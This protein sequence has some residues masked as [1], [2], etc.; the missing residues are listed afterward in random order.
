MVASNT[1]PT[2]FAALLFLLAAT[3]SQAKGDIIDGVTIYDFSSEFAAFGRVADNLINGSGLAGDLHEATDGVGMWHTEF[4]DLVPTENNF[5]HITFDL[6]STYDIDEIVV[7]NYGEFIDLTN[8]TGFTRRGVRDLRVSV[9]STLDST[10]FSAVGDFTLSRASIEGGFFA[11]E[12]LSIT[13]N[14]VRLVRFD[15]FSNLYNDWRSNEDVVGLSEVRFTGSL[16]SIPEPSSPL[17]IGFLSVMG[18]AIR[19]RSI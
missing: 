18:F 16:S 4:E 5:A 17:F 3:V 6:G 8:S 2:R 15:I 19:R 11:S 12:S 7:W 14:K 1:M 13:A 9:A 10:A